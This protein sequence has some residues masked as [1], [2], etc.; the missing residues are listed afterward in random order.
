M[1]PTPRCLLDRER[2]CGG[3]VASSPADCPYT[4]L[5]QDTEEDVPTRYADGASRRWGPPST[6]AAAANG[7]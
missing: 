6:V 2:P 1:T 3:C 7:P 5:L 4:F